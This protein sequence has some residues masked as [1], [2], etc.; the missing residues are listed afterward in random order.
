MACET[1]QQKITHKGRENRKIQDLQRQEGSGECVWNISE[2][3]QVTTGHNGAKP[4]VIRNIVFTCVVLHN[5][6]RTYQGQTVRALT[7]ADDIAAL[8]NQQVVNLPD[9]YRNRSRDAKHQQDLLKDY[10]NHLDALAG[11]EDRISDVST[12]YPGDRRSWHL[13][14]LFRTTQLFQ[15]LSFKQMLH[16]I[17]NNFPKRGFQ[18]VSK[19]F[20]TKSQVPE[21]C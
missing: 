19:L 14:V 16:K 21:Y 4:K 7:P 2:Q 5:M 9:D 12:N 17:P 15:E 11:Q 1:P 20:L 18:Q 6:L 8:Q 13:S 3:I 10:I